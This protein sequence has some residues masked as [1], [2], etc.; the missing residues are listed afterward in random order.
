[1]ILNDRDGKGGKAHDPHV[2]PNRVNS[3]HHKANNYWSKLEHQYHQQ[4]YPCMTCAQTFNKEVYPLCPTC[5]KLECR[6]CG[7]L[8]HWLTNPKHKSFVCN[9]CDYEEMNITQVFYTWMLN[10]PDMELNEAAKK[11][12][13][14]YWR[15]MKIDEL[16]PNAEVSAKF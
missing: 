16:W 8:Q 10:A 9:C 12:K 3:I 7:N 2:C 14:L 13:A 15:R 6:R 4:Y 1:M 5:F 11:I